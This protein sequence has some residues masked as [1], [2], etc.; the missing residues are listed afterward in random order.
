MRIFA[1]LRSVGLAIASIK[2]WV[3]FFV[4]VVPAV[5]AGIGGYLDGMPWYWL[6]ALIPAVAGSFLWLML[7]VFAAWNWLMNWRELNQ[8]AADLMMVKEAG[9]TVLPIAAVS[10]VWPGR[11]ADKWRLNHHLRSLKRA[12]DIGWLTVVSGARFPSDM[13]SVVNV[14]EVIS[15]YKS[16]RI[17]RVWQQ[18]KGQHSKM[19]EERDS[20]I[21]S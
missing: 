14:E 16:G 7:G 20:S 6:M 17:R 8:A 15:L 13:K 19:P 18:E 3:L 9:H 12:A 11:N 4:S 5:M 21:G 10:D 2:G 1:Q